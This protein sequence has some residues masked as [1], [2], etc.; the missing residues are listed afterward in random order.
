MSRK[1]KPPARRGKVVFDTPVYTT[2][3]LCAR[4]RISRRTLRRW[5]NERAFPAGWQSG[6]NVVYAKQQCHDWEKIHTPALH[7]EPDLTE[8]DKHWERL[9]RRYLLEK[10]ERE[11]APPPPPRRGPP[12]RARA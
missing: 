2:A 7:T 3:E 9:R 5:T 4:H 10:E 6:K 12:P 1:P 8:E 11:A